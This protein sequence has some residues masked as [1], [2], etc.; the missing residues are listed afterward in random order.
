M[1]S[2]LLKTFKK[3]E[4]DRIKCISNLNG[5]GIDTPDDASLSAIAGKILEK[6]PGTKFEDNPLIWKRPEDWPDTK[7]LLLNAPVVEGY[8]PV[9]LFLLHDNRDT[10]TLSITGQ[11]V[12]SVY[13][14]D[15]YYLSDG[16]FVEQPSG[17]SMSQV[18][19]T[20]DKT[21]DI[22]TTLGYNLRYVITYAKNSKTVNSVAKLFDNVIGVG[23]SLLEMVYNPIYGNVTWKIPTR[24]T[25]PNYTLNLLRLHILESPEGEEDIDFCTSN[26]S[27]LYHTIREIELEHK[28][29]LHIERHNFSRGFETAGCNAK[30]IAKNL[31][32]IFRDTTYGVALNFSYIYAPELEEIKGTKGYTTLSASSIYAPKLKSINTGTTSVGRES[33]NRLPLL[34]NMSDYSCVSIITAQ[35]YSNKLFSSLVVDE[36]SSVPN[37]F[38]SQC[39]YN[40]YIKKLS[41]VSPIVSSSGRNRFIFPNLKEITLDT[42]F[43]SNYLYELIIGE[44][45]KSNLNLSSVLYL[46]TINMLDILNKLADVT[47][48]ETTYTLTLSTSLKNIL[49][50]QELAIATNKGW[51]IE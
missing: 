36:L 13:A 3:I 21:K 33:F 27:H 37:G 5:V 48:E 2:E 40:K 24:Q 17:N 16:T 51:I 1:A 6:A 11:S 14:S 49:S 43:N 30:L 7:K 47:N 15:Y 35:E 29:T 25:S 19:H 34:Q 41:F 45:F 10:I 31:K 12:S 22:E 20:W 26:S 32:G 39:L 9:A 46:T 44:G 42:T 50:E 8:T 23:I 28:G 38:G 4:Q 18:T